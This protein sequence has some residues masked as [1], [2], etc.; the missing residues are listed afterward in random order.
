MFWLCVH[1]QCDRQM[2]GR[3]DMHSNMTRAAYN[4]IVRM[5]TELK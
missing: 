3:T 1:L 2:D 5:N 4:P